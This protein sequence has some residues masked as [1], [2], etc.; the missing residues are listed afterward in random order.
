MTNEFTK[1]KN[2]RTVTMKISFGK[3][4]CPKC[5]HGKYVSKPRGMFCTKC[6]YKY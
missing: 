2:K 3:K 4:T 1:G 5:G 6:K